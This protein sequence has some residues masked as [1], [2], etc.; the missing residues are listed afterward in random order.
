MCFLFRLNRLI[1]LVFR[2]GCVSIRVKKPVG[3]RRILIGMQVRVEQVLSGLPAASLGNRLDPH[4]LVMQGRSEAVAAAME[5]Q[6]LNPGCRCSTVPGVPSCGVG[7]SEGFSVAGEV[8][9]SH[10]K[11]RWDVRDSFFANFRLAYEHFA[12]LKINIDPSDSESF[13]NP[14]AGCEQEEG[15]SS[16]ISSV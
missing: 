12:S 7:D 5:G 13:R 14:C 6:A 15:E 1:L 8:G 10:E 11:L 4:A 2:F 16:N 9:Q 3:D